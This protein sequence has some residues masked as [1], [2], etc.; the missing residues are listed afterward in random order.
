[1]GKSVGGYTD[2]AAAPNGDLYT[3][4]GGYAKVYRSTNGGTSFDSVAARPPGS[5]F[6]LCVTPGGT[7]LGAEPAARS[8]SS[9]DNGATWDTASSA[10]SGADASGGQVWC[11]TGGNYYINTGRYA[12]KDLYRMQNPD[13]V[14]NYAGGDLTLQ[15]GLGT[16][17][18]AVSGIVA[19][20]GDPDTSGIT[21]QSAATAWI[22]RSTGTQ[23]FLPFMF[24]GSDSVAV[25]SV[26]AVTDSVYIWWNTGKRTVFLQSTP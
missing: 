1:V 2:L 19:K 4:G 8:Y 17:N 12:G 6:N 15:A 23:M 21:P 18:S 13:P 3:I 26:T 22:T 20:V 16:G 25:D 7:I 10:I 24:A 5:I 11:D 14:L 9:T